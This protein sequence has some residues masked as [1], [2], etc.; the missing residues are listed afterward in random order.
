MTIQEGISA[1]SRYGYSSVILA[2]L[3]RFKIFNLHTS[4]T[5]GISAKC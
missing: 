2:D 5:K 4:K 1:N 3:L